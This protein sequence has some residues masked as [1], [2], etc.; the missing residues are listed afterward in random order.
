[1]RAVLRPLRSL[2]VSSGKSANLS[3][4]TILAPPENQL[5]KPRTLKLRATNNGETSYELYFTAQS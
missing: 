2:L 1:M 5:Q 3:M 4:A